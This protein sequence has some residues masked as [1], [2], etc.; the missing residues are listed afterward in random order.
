M[1]NTQKMTLYYM[2]GFVDDN[3]LEI[4]YK[5]LQEMTNYQIEIEE[6]SPEEAAIYA[7]DREDIENG[8]YVTMEEIMAK[9]GEIYEDIDEGTHLN[10]KLELIRPS[11][12]SR[13]NIHVTGAMRSA[14]AKKPKAAAVKF[15]RTAG[16]AKNAT[17][18]IRTR[19][20]RPAK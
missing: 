16:V 9:R 1:T 17:A 4:I 3:Q 7:N 19:K 11:R 12:D 5:M 15:P 2:L 13:K 20:A 10:R 18:P 8:N 14:A 6:L